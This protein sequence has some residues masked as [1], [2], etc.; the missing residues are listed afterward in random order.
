[1]TLRE[2][3]V[4]LSAFPVP[5]RTVEMFATKRGLTLDE[6]AN[7]FNLSSPAYKLVE[8]DI[9]MWIFLS[10]N[11]G[12]GGQSYS[13]GDRRQFRRL[14]MNI[15][16]RFGSEDDLKGYSNGKYGYMGSRL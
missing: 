7:S 2:S 13:F 1:M 12:Q 10:P 4:A 11:V 3:I 9:Y 14:A 5:M 16:E 6:E 15:S 8:A